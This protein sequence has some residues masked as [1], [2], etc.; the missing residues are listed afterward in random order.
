MDFRIKSAVAG[1]TPIIDSYTVDWIGI[2]NDVL[3][4]L[5]SEQGMVELADI[6]GYYDVLGELIEPAKQNL[7]TI[8]DNHEQ[9]EDFQAWYADYKGKVLKKI[10]DSILK[11]R[12]AEAQ[13]D[14]D[15]QVLDA[16]ERSLR[17][18]ITTKTQNE[19]AYIA[20]E[21]SQSLAIEAYKH[22]NRITS[23]TQRL[24]TEQERE[25][26]RTQQAERKKMLMQRI[27]Y[28][29]RALPGAEQSMT[30]PVEVRDTAKKRSAF[31]FIGNFWRSFRDGLAG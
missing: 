29:S 7:Q 31:G 1:N 24:T 30:I 18:K 25:A 28:G 10:G 23:Q 16:K 17:T 9:L 26:I 19:L 21:L 12:K 5:S 13:F 14:S 2:A 8:L 11:A 4:Y 22:S 3:H 20:T 6:A 27:R 15:L